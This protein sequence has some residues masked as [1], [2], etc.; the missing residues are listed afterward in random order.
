[1]T[2]PNKNSAEQETSTESPFKDIL[3]QALNNPKE[4][5]ISEKKEL[6]TVEQA[7]LIIRKLANTFCI[8]EANAFAAMCALFL[9]GAANKGTPAILSVDVKTEDGSY[10]T[11]TKYDLTIACKAATKHTFLRRVA[12][13]MA[14]EIGMYAEKANYNGDLAIKLNNELVANNQPPLSTKEKA[15][16]SSFNQNLPKLEEYAGERIPSLLA[17]DYRKRFMDKNYK[18]PEKK[19]M[20]KN[21]QKIP[22]TKTQSG[23]KP[24][25]APKAEKKIATPRSRKKK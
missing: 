10:T 5:I 22:E 24:D 12:E 2:Q 15:W 7:K 19:P 1:M 25:S 11:I 18:T 9:K 4:E 3:G 21:S 23:I 17:Q 20:E 14:L 6:V 13:A 16:A 8:T